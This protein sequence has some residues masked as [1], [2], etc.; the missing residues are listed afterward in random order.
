MNYKT[1]I[2]KISLLEDINQLL[3]SIYKQELKP[4]NLTEI[5]EISLKSYKSF[6]EVPIC[7]KKKLKAVVLISYKEIRLIKNHRKES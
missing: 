2:G 7:L 3:F 5:E 1:C 6:A 4:I